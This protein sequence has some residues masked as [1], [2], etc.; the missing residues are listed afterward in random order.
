MFHDFFQ[1]RRVI[2]AQMLCRPPRRPGHDLD[3][4]EP[5]LRRRIETIKNRKIRILESIAKAP[6]VHRSDHL[7]FL[8]I[9]SDVYHQLTSSQQYSPQPLPFLYETRTIFCYYL[10]KMDIAP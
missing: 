2:R 6:G 1:M 10:P 8:S 5:R 3:S 4:S 9:L 7:Y